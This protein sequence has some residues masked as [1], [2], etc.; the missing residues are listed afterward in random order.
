MVLQF[1]PSAPGFKPD[2]NY[3]YFGN[4]CRAGAVGVIIGTTTSAMRP[5]N[6]VTGTLLPN[7]SVAS[8]GS[9]I[10][11][12]IKLYSNIGN[13]LV[14]R[15]LQHA[16]LDTGVIF[17]QIRNG[18]P[19]SKLLDLQVSARYTSVYND[20]ES[21]NILGK[22]TGSDPLLKN[23]FVFHTA[24]LDHVGVGKPID[25]DS[26]YNGAHDNASGVASLIE[27][28]KLYARLQVKPKRSIILSFVTGEEMGLLGSGYYIKLPT[29]DRKS[30]VADINTDMPTIIAP[31]LSAVAIG[32]EHSSI[33][34]SVIKAGNYLHIDI[35]KDPEPEQN[36]F[37]RSD[38][39][40]FVKAGIPAIHVKYGNKTADGNNNLDI[41]VKAWREKYYHKPQDDINAIFDFE[42][43]KSYVQFNFL[44]SYFIAQDTARPT[45]NQGSPFSSAGE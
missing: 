28:G 12:A 5:V 8:S 32:A 16:G 13:A 15:F 27:I 11:P 6:S 43:G 24:H 26:I 42:A 22:I 3:P 18:N 21:A 40:S 31:F 4:G 45:W 14:H 37:V 38:Q 29:V 25:G 20:F 7:G 44:I 35:D 33:S 36:R 17:S 34:Q 9:Y 39:Y 1:F 41:K 2:R 23:E 30:I 10:S 19:S